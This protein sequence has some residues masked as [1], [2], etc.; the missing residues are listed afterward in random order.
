MTVS[1]YRKL[2]FC[3]NFWPPLLCAFALH[4]SPD[5]WPITIPVFVFIGI[6]QWYS[7]RVKE[8]GLRRIG[9]LESQD[10]DSRGN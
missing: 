2:A 6:A 10:K 5:E 7:F 3:F 4:L 9:A 1:F 8:Q